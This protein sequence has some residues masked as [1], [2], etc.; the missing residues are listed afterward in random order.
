MLVQLPWKAWYKTARWRKLRLTVF[1]RDH[2]T[3]Q[4]GCGQLEADT[5]RLVCDHKVPHRGD[6][7]LRATCTRYGS[8]ATIA[9]SSV[10]SNR[11]FTSVASG[12]ERLRQI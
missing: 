11:P 4:C 1:L 12:T 3:C 9:T 8:P 6:E 7:R 5:S 2:Y 10:P